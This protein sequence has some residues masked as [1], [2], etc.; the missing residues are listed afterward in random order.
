MIHLTTTFERTVIATAAVVLSTL[1]LLA[2]EA[3]RGRPAPI[4]RR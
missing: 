1:T 2:A 3:G 4:S